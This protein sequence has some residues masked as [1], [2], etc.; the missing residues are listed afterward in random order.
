M[1]LNFRSI[2][3]NPFSKN[4]IYIRVIW[5]YVNA[6]MK[7]TLLL[8]TLL[9]LSLSTYSQKFEYGTNA[10]LK[11]L[12]KIF[13]DTGT[14]METRKRIIEVINKAK[15]PGIE[16]LGS[17]D[18]A[19]I[20]MTFGGET[21]ETITGATTNTTPN[22]YVITT[23]TN[24]VKVP[25]INGAGTVFVANKGGSKPKLILSVQNSQQSRLEKRPSTKFANAFIKA[26]KE[27]NGTK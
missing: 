6:N 14:D 5:W 7:M 16:F 11:G 17:A 3:V 26:Y 13:L 27:A 24:Y 22:P 15:L 18:E 8:I 10:D 20:Y 25:L 23:T 21:V 9:A 2:S 1:L 4:S 12:T 19:E